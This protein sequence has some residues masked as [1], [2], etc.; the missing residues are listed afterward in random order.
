MDFYKVYH[1]KLQHWSTLVVCTDYFFTSAYIQTVAKFCNKSS[2][3]A[4]FESYLVF[5]IKINNVSQI[6]HLLK[7]W[8][9]MFTYTIKFNIKVNMVTQL[10]INFHHL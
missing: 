7:G 2:F 3:N 5:E 4:N 6:L 1:L 9:V 8:K 10:A